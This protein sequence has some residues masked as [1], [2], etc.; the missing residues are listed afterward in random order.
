MGIFYQPKDFY[1]YLVK[2][3]VG[4][5]EKGLT[6]RY[7]FSNKYA[8]N[9]VAGILL[10]NFSPDLLFNPLS[11][12]YKLKLKMEVKFYYQNEI[13]KTY[14]V[15]TTYSPFIGQRGSG[16]S[17]IY[18]KSPIDLPLKKQLVCEINIIEPDEE[19]ERLY[20]PIRFYISKMSDE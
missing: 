13:V 10:D 19:L 15:D 11:Q 1:E 5:S 20:G 12:K 16:F 3:E 17:L 8:G 7:V 4:I 9:H 6:R 18:Y 2:E 14:F